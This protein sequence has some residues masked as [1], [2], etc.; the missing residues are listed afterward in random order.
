MHAVC[1]TVVHVCVNLQIICLGYLLQ[2]QIRSKMCITS[3]LNL[4][5]LDE[6]NPP[7]QS[8]SGSSLNCTNEGT[9]DKDLTKWALFKTL[10]NEILTT[11]CRCVDFVWRRGVLW[12]GDFWNIIYNKQI[13]ILPPKSQRPPDKNP[14]RFHKWYGWIKLCKKRTRLLVLP[15]RWYQ[16]MQRSLVCINTIILLCTITCLEKRIQLQQCLFLRN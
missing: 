5:C 7:I 3:G 2:K 10:W 13:I 11:I 4:T 15:A 16:L 14:H 8:C 1:S 9:L 12:G 6:K